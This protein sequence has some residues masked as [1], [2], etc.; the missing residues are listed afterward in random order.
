LSRYTHTPP[1]AD[2][3]RRNEEQILPVLSSVETVWNRCERAL[4]R[5]A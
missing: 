4:E 2:K 3:W 5:R 1:S